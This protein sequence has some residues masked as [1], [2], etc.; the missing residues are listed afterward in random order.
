MNKLELQFRKEL[1]S[2]TTKGL[3]GL[4]LPT[5]H[6]ENHLNPGVPDLSYVMLKSDRETGWLELKV[7]PDENLL[8]FHIEP[9]QHTWMRQH[10]E[11]VPAHFLLATPS[12]C[13]L[14]NGQFHN[15][16][17]VP[18]YP[19]ELESISVATFARFNLRK[20]LPAQLHMVSCRSTN[21][22]SR[23]L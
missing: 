22:Y 12:M 18:I 5:I 2:S 4:W 6:V 23:V 3:M 9:G 13:Y 19:A 7:V 17:A 16:L 21:A 20:V 14:M 10:S 15:A 11:R 1:I 8:H